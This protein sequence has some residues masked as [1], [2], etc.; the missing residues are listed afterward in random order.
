MVGFDARVR[1]MIDTRGNIV[2]PA[3]EYTYISDVSGGVVAVWST[4]NGWE[5]LHKMA[6]FQ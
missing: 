4:E 1:M 2:I 5:I 3:G 6:K